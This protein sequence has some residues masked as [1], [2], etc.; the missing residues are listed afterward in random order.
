MNLPLVIGIT[1]ASGVIYGVEIL[2]AL[3]TLEVPT[4]LIITEAGARTLILETEIAL[5]EI[6]A[7]ADV[8]HS[9]RDIAASISSGSFLTR[10]MIVAPC[11]IKTLSS[12]AN[13]YDADL[14]AR[15]A[16]VTLKERR[17]LVL[18]VRETPL[19][20]GHL[21]LMTRAADYGATILPPMP[22]FYHKPQI[23]QDIVDQGV[24]RAL[25]QLGITHAL[26]PRWDDQDT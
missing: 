11:S 12:I 5:A 23:L 21:D 24:A 19:H 6:K 7:L 18:M 3:K 4:H 9:N 14:V 22:A 8:V 1:G 2:R 16:D 13:S 15:A 10:G 26:F 17:P 20:K 25:D